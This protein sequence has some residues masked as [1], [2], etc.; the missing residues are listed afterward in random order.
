MIAPGFVKDRERQ[1]AR[2]FPKGNARA[3]RVKNRRTKQQKV[4]TLL[5]CIFHVKIFHFIL[6]SIDIVKEI[7]YN[8]LSLQKI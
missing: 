3:C 4:L 1:S 7:T 6:L 8:R 5:F 2:A